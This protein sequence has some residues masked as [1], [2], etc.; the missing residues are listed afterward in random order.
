[1]K[2]FGYSYLIG[3]PAVR[4][5]VQEK[6]VTAKQYVFCLLVAIAAMGASFIGGYLWGLTCFFWG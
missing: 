5:R 2:I 6:T 3:D 4:A 1:M